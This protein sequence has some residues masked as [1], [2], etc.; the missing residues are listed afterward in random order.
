MRSSYSARAFSAGGLAEA[1]AQFGGILQ[2]GNGGGQRPGIAHRDEQAFNAVGHHLPAARHIGGDQR[3]PAGRGLDQPLGQALAVARQHDG[4]DRPEQRRHVVH[5]AQPLHQ[6]LFHPAAHRSFRHG[7]RIARVRIPGQQEVDRPALC[8]Q[9][10]RGLDVLGQA[11]VPE[12]AR[13]SSTRKQAAP[14]RGRCAASSE[15]SA[16]LP[17]TGWWLRSPSTPPQQRSRRPPGDRAVARPRSASAAAD[18]SATPSHP[19]PG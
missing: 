4:I 7:R 14:A 17:A 15:S 2:A 12:Q 13:G 11:L 9:Q 19:P 5:M 18:P 16:G 8:P 10:P 6:A 1:G 3:Q